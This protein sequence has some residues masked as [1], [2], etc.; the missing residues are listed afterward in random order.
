MKRHLPITILVLAL[1]LLG[2]PIAAADPFT[3]KPA[4]AGTGADLSSITEDL[5][6]G[7]DNTYSIGSVAAGVKDIH[8]EGKLYMGSGASIEDLD[9]LDMGDDILEIPN[10]TDP[11][12]NTI[13]QIA[14]DTDGANET[15]DVSLRGY[16]GSNQ[17]SFARKIYAIHTT[18]VK[19]N[20]LADA[21]R[22]KMLIWSNESGMIFT[23]TKIEAW[24]DTD[25]TAFTVEE[26]DADGAS[27][28]TDIDA[29]NCTTGSGPYTAT[30]TTI[31]AA[32]V[33]ANHVIALDFDDTDDPGWV[34]VTICGWYNADVD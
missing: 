21:T 2:P 10:G 27:N 4:T 17:F 24:A 9:N 28:Q 8:L 1:T 3:T 14:Q 15:G 6:F 30:E 26:Y 23:I 18:V 33:E 5:L 31:T 12:L 13:G 22:D 16:D 32:T 7:A 19:P 29:V 34:K 25:D 20:D 11:D